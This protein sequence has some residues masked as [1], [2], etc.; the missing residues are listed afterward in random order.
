MRGSAGASREF[1]LAPSAQGATLGP[2][3][4]TA[5]LSSS[6]VLRPG[7]RLTSE[8]VVNQTGA[9]VTSALHFAYENW[10]SRG[11][12]DEAIQSFFRNVWDDYLRRVGAYSLPEGA[13]FRQIHEGHGTFIQP[14]E[15]SFVAPE[16]IRGTC[17]VGEPE[18]LV[19]QI[20]AMEAAGI[21]ETV[22]EPPADFQHEVYRDFAE[23]VMPAFR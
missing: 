20:R 19:A 2:G 3:F 13:R 17:L 6:C 12:S 23:L 18:E 22:I 7:E 14:E 1:A 9:Q 5:A 16:A 15:R 8:R 4:H 10:K 11:Q 21:K